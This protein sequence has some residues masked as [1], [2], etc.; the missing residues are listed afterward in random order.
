MREIRINYNTLFAVMQIYGYQRTYV[1]QRTQISKEGA[2]YNYSIGSLG[3]RPSFLPRGP[4]SK[5]IDYPISI[6][7]NMMIL[8]PKY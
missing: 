3:P 8:Q 7:Y 1:F 2:R 4:G 5:A 6:Y